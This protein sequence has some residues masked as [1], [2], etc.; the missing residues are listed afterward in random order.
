MPIVPQDWLEFI[1]LL[2]AKGVECVLVGGHAVAYYGR[3][4]LTQDID[5]LDSCED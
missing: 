5:Q 2:N 4:R 3:S 1:D